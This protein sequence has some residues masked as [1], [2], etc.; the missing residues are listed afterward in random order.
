[1]KNSDFL[2]KYSD[3][4]EKLS[5]FQ[6]KIIT[7]LEVAPTPLE[8]AIKQQESPSPQELLDA[9]QDKGFSW[10]KAAVVAIT[11]VAASIGVQDGRIPPI[12]LIGAIGG[13][14]CLLFFPQLRALIE[15]L[16]A[17]AK[18]EEEEEEKS[19][20]LNA[21]LINEKLKRIR[22]RYKSARFLI[23]V[24]T[25]YRSTPDALKALG[26]DLAIYDRSQFFKE[27]LNHEFMNDIS[28]IM[29][30]ADHN[31]EYRRNIIFASMKPN[32][33]V[34]MPQAQPR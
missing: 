3:F 10:P 34:N 27:T 28:D 6:S 7:L 5:I 14:L 25:P 30:H 24:Q 32:P 11:I 20:F 13:S 21:D 33:M 23:K 12:V 4:E 16:M 8:A 1:V 2:I 18:E 17:I 31:I 9:L 26:K 29:V 15:Y 19:E 22:D